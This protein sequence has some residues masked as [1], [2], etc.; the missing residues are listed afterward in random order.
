MV[1]PVS[2]GQHCWVQGLQ[3]AITSCFKLPTFVFVT[4]PLL[5]REQKCLD[6][7]GKASRWTR[8]VWALSP[9]SWSALLGAHCTLAL[10]GNG[11]L[12]SSCVAQPGFHGCTPGVAGHTG[13]K[14]P[15]GPMRPRV[16]LGVG[17]WLQEVRSTQGPGGLPRGC[18][19]SRHLSPGDL[20]RVDVGPAASLWQ[21][22]GD[23]RAQGVEPSMSW[24]WSGLGARGEVSGRPR[25]PLGLGGSAAGGAAAWGPRDLG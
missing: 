23:S 9:R 22:A 5:S 1:K 21:T 11:S 2:S 10:L 20:A 17:Y 4:L 7:Q 18:G 25:C 3:G 15:Q 12:S 14:V 16:L 6:G 13:L 8:T 24:L 19:L